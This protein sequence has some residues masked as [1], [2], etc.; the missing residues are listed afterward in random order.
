MSI[1][2]KPVIPSSGVPSLEESE[3]IEKTLEE[4]SQNNKRAYQALKMSFLSN[5]NLVWKNRYGLTP[6]KVVEEIGTD[7]LKLFQV[8][9]KL[10]E[11]FALLGD[12]I[13]A[14]IPEGIEYTPNEDGSIT[15]K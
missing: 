9:A 8:S 14:P 15:I 4:I 7:A 10:E 5:S 1:E 13:T 6:K 11:L 12:N 2:F 3:K